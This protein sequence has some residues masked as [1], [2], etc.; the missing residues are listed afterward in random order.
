[1]K[2]EKKAAPKQKA[3]ASKKA[4]A[5]PKQA[6]ARCKALAKVHARL[7]VNPDISI[8]E[9]EQVMA[10][11]PAEQQEDLFEQELDADLNWDE[12]NPFEEPQPPPEPA[13]V[14]PAAKKAAAKKVAAKKPAAKKPPAQKD[15]KKRERSC[16]RSDN[17][18]LCGMR[19]T[20]ETG[21]VRKKVINADG[22][23]AF[24]PMFCPTFDGDIDGWFDKY[25]ETSK[26]RRWK[27]DDNK[28]DHSWRERKKAEEGAVKLEAA[29]EE[30]PPEGHV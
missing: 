22:K 24:T 10:A 28:Q 30:E 19:A 17:G 29:Q 18:E 16:L 26:S 7:G 15:E 20:G 21:H 4:A 9:M 2:A 3:A 27:A 1:M 6:R 23:I 13:L 8:E 5:E 11:P 14:E 25:L 12:E